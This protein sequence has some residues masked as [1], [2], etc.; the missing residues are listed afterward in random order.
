[1]DTPERMNGPQLIDP[2][3]DDFLMEDRTHDWI[4]AASAAILLISAIAAIIKRYED[5]DNRRY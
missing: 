1:M 3:R 2:H 5:S 4:R